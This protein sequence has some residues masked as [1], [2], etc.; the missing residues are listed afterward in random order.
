MIIYCL[1]KY[2]DLFLLDGDSHFSKVNWDSP[3]E[4]FNLYLESFRKTGS[5]LKIL[6]EVSI[7][8]L[9]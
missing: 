4:C 7:Q 8:I 6:I 1:N 5:I 2:H 9:A 3:E